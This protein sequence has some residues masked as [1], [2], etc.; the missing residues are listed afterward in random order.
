MKEIENKEKEDKRKLLKY[1]IISFITSCI[2]SFITNNKS[3]RILFIISG[4]FQLLSI[5]SIISNN[6][7]LLELMH[8]VMTTIILITFSIYNTI[9]SNIYGIFIVLIILLTR[10]KYDKCL[11]YNNQ[12]EA[13]E[14]FFSFVK[15]KNII[16]NLLLFYIIIQLYKLINII[17]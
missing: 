16:N 2:F 10:F 15:D 5:S 11:F 6:Y 14:G 7:I 3:D 4:F 17:K 8:G 1:I 12:Y 9:Y 13:N